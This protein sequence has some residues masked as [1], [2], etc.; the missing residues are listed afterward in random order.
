M[1][2]WWQ[3]ALSIVLMLAATYIAFRAAAKVFRIG[4]LSTGKRPSLSEILR[5]ARS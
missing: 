3:I 5:W 1:P 2:P 4:T